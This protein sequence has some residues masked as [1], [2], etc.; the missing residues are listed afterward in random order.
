MSEGSM[1][2]HRWQFLLRNTTAKQ[3]QLQTFSTEISQ[4]RLTQS[5]GCGFIELG[6]QDK[7]ARSGSKLDPFKRP[8]DVETQ[9]LNK[10]LYGSLKRYHSD[11]W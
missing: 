8:L 3:L 5:D 10:S 7:Y 6:W 4:T 9:G 1:N 2:L 11:L